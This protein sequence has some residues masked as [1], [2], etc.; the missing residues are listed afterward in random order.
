MHNDGPIQILESALAE[1]AKQPTSS[2]RESLLHALLKA[3]LWIAARGA[4]S[5]PSDDSGRVDTDTNIQF[6]TG[7]GPEGRVAFAFSSV[8]EARKV[9]PKSGLI[10]LD[11]RGIAGLI[12]EELTGIVINA[13]SYPA[14]ISRN[15]L[16]ELA[17][18]D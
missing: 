7:S 8:A 5:I 14:F 15:E 17:S 12:S 1:F 11:V 3:P 9:D 18:P 6:L 10:A 13:G 2:V 4:E 16:K